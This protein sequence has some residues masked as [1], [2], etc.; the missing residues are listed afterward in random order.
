MTDPQTPEN[1]CYHQGDG[2][3]EKTVTTD[4]P[5][6][7]QRAL[8]LQHLN[9]ERARINVKIRAL[10]HKLNGLDTCE[11]KYEKWYASI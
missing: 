6:E 2:V 11:R 8:Y 7:E 4:L 10:H 3:M 9:R 5:L 1:D